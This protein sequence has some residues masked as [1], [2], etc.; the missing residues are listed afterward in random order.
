MKP[1]YN[2]RESVYVKQCLKCLH[3][4]NPN[5]YLRKDGTP[6]TRCPKC[7]SNQM[8]DTRLYPPPIIVREDL[9]MLTDGEY[10][11]RYS[12]RTAY[13]E[14]W[15]NPKTTIDEKT[16]VRL[17][18]CR[19]F[20]SIKW[21]H[22]VILKERGVAGEWMS[23]CEE[24][25]EYAIKAVEKCSNNARVFIAGL[26]LGLILLY[27]AKSR[28]ARGVIV[29]EINQTIIDLVEPRLRR[30][31]SERYP[32]FNWKVIHGDAFRVI[33]DLGKFDWIYVDIWS[34]RVSASE[35]RE[36]KERMAPYLTKEGIITC[37]MEDESH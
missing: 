28:K 10:P 27:L 3:I 2:L 18:V 17:A 20:A 30:W 33:K 7:H 21:G 24:E 22:Y 25:H 34:K 31:F 4:W 11:Q 26:G 23:T 32:D 29:A 14:M 19:G 1:T 13:E 37:W 8:H 5:S 15:C 35:I 9:L 36:A 16:G 12:P 6:R